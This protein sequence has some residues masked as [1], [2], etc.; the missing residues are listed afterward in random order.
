MWVLTDLN[1]GRPCEDDTAPGTREGQCNESAP[2]AE[3]PTLGS[4]L[5]GELCP[6]LIT[7]ILPASLLSFSP[8][9]C[10]LHRSFPS[11]MT[12]S[13][14]VQWGMCGP[15]IRE[16]RWV[17]KECRIWVSP[18]YQIQWQPAQSLS[19]GLPA[20]ACHL[21]G[22][23]SGTGTY[24]VSSSRALSTGGGGRGGARTL[25]NGESGNCRFR[26]VQFFWERSV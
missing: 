8:Q 5:T 13:G 21:Q 14:P 17:G 7:P 16:E 6:G 22:S 9:L 1:S 3:W 19:P 25:A 12:T 24:C 11:E 23:P 2:S 4:F 15:A 10:H 20:P 26:F 18:K